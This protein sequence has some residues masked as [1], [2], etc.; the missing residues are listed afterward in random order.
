MDS[1][2]CLH[3]RNKWLLK[4]KRY[5]FKRQVDQTW[6]FC[7]SLPLLQHQCSINMWWTTELE[8]KQKPWERERSFWQ[9]SVRL[10]PTSWLSSTKHQKSDEI[11]DRA[12]FSPPPRPQLPSLHLVNHEMTAWG[13]GQPVESWWWPEDAEVQ[14]GARVPDSR[15]RAKGVLHLLFWITRQQF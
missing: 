1:Y 9:R 4:A 7:G 5:K 14:T 12:G 13:I 3:Y 6:C 10:A 11:L 15:S 2:W 8:K